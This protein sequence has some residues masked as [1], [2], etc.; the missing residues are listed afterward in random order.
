MK[1]DFKLVSMQYSLEKENHFQFNRIKFAAATVH[2]HSD[3]SIS[4][5]ERTNERTYPAP[6]LP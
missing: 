3:I 5:D 4:I 2:A 1:N 6:S